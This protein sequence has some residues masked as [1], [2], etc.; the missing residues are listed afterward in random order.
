MERKFKFE[1]GQYIKIAEDEL[2]K[3]IY[4]PNY[5]SLQDNLSVL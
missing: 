1:V 2:K 4:L 5:P 3:R